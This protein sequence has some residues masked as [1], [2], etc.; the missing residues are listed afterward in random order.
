VTKFNWN[1]FD[2]LVVPSLEHMR[3]TGCMFRKTCDDECPH[4]DD[5]A[6]VHC[7][8]SN[9]IIFIKDTPEAMAKYIAQKLEGV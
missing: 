7:N 2:C 9:D 3:C 5:G 8:A 6:P 4:T 1:G